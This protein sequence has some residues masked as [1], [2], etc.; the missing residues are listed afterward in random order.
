MP[1]IGFLHTQSPDVYAHRL[2]GFRQGLREAGYVEG[3]NV[4]IE[5]RWAEKSNGSVAS[6]GGRSGSPEGRRNL[7]DRGYAS[8]FAA[9]AATATIP[10]VFAVADD[11]VR[12]GFV[13]SLARPGGNLRRSNSPPIRPL[14]RWRHIKYAVVCASGCQRRPA[15]SKAALMPFVTLPAVYQ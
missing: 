5:Y 4:A 1:V 6:A 15:C 13:A 14:R 11:P 12:L 9:K 2:R 10:I 7:R 8:T 3:E